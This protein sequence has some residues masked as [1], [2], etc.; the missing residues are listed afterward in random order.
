M[1]TATTAN[2]AQNTLIKVILALQYHPRSFVGCNNL[3]P[4]IDGGVPEIT[5]KGLMGVVV[6]VGSGQPTHIE[7]KTT[8]RN[9]KIAVLQKRHGISTQIRH[10]YVCVNV[11]KAL[12]RALML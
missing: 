6:P 4:I 9:N 11:R 5:V 10:I 1:S 3:E 12:S 2:G 8:I 7:T